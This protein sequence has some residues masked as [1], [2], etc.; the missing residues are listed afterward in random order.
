MRADKQYTDWSDALH[1]FRP[2]AIRLLEE[3]GPVA[4][5]DSYGEYFVAGE[6]KG[7]YACFEYSYE[8]YKP[9]MKRPIADVLENDYV[10]TPGSVSMSQ[11]Q[12][13]DGTDVKVT[14]IQKGM[15]LD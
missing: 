1:S 3:Q 10:W 15:H 9:S 6:K 2:E 12:S 8:V 4:F 7:G 14:S 5:A 13:I 11:S